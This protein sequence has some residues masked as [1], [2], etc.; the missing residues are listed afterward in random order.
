MTWCVAHAKFIPIWQNI[1]TII[2]DEKVI[3]IGIVAFYVCVVLSYILAFFEQLPYDM[4][5]VMLKM[6]QV[7]LC[8]PAAFF[9]KNVPSR[10]LFAG[11]SYVGILVYTTIISFYMVIIKLSIDEH[12]IESRN[13]LI[14]NKFHLAGDANTRIAIEK[15]QLVTSLIAP[16]SAA[17]IYA[18]F[19][20][21]FPAI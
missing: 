14:D 3:F 13:E 19:L 20:F 16:S 8:T 18:A 7:I 11:G 12:Q 4:Y 6:L 2:K 10:I 1:V 5:T 21:S 17:F 9:P 15:L